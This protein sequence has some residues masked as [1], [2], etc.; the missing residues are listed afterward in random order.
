MSTTTPNLTL[1]DGVIMAIGVL[2]A[3]NKDTACE[4]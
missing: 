4:Q 1:N 3:H 2:V